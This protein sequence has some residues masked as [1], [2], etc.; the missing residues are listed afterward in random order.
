MNE[1]LDRY[2]HTVNHRTLIEKSMR[3]EQQEALRDRDKSSTA[4]S[5][6]QMLMDLQHL[7]SSGRQGVRQSPSPEDICVMQLDI[8]LHASLSLLSSHSCISHFAN[9]DFMLRDK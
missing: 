7:T 4:I 9:E 5:Y 8:P 3:V 1:I 6:V 2:I